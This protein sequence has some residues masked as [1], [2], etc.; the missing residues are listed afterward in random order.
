VIEEYK[1]LSD[2]LHNEH[3]DAANGE[4]LKRAQQAIDVLNA[5][6]INDFNHYMHAQTKKRLAQANHESASLALELA[7]LR[8]RC[9]ELM[10]QH[11][12]LNGLG[13][14]REAVRQVLHYMQCGRLK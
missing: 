2:E 4:L 8:E 11:E 13:V 3:Y 7:S 10:S 9:A 14:D 5:P 1:M 6:G 12:P